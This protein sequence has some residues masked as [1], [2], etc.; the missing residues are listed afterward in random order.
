MREKAAWMYPWSRR[1]HLLDY[2][3]VWRR[4]QRNVLMTKV[5]GGPAIARHLRDTDSSTASQKTSRS[6][7]TSDELAQRPVNIPVAAAAADVT[8]SVEK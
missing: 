1:R 4:D 7:T 2:V 3:L 8:A 6:A 5:A